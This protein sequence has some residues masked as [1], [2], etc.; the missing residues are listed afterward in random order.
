MRALVLD[1]GIYKV[2]T[3]HVMNIAVINIKTQPETKAKAQKIARE[4]GVSLSSLLN[5][6]LKQLIKTKTVT[7]SAREEIPN[8]RTLRVL[9]RAEENYKKGNT[10]P[11]FKNIEDELKWLEDQGI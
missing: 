6:Y 7:F 10:S 1:I 9:K 8:A 3:K 2:H 4:I 11:A 5:A